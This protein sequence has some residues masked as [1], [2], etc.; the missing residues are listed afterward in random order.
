MGCLFELRAKAGVDVGA[1]R[2]R[3]LLPGSVIFVRKD[4]CSRGR[5]SAVYQYWLT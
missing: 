2:E 5:S 1:R 3:R 4:G